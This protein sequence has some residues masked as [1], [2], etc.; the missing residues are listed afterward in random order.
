M[1]EEDI[2]RT[3]LWPS[4]KVLNQRSQLLVKGKHKDGY[5]SY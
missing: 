3:Q 5:T 1:I 4:V 2:S